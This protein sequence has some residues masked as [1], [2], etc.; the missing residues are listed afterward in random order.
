MSRDGAPNSRRSLSLFESASAQ[1]DESLFPPPSKT[2]KPLA[3]LDIMC[4]FKLRNGGIRVAGRPSSETGITGQ[5]HHATAFAL[6]KKGF[7]RHLLHEELRSDTDMKRRVLGYVGRLSTLERYQATMST[8]LEG[9]ETSSA[10]KKSTEGLVAGTAETVPAKPEALIKNELNN[11]VKEVLGIYSEKRAFKQQLRES[12]NDLQVDRNTYKGMLKDDQADIK[13]L[14]SGDPENKAREIEAL[15][16]LFKRRV[17]RGDR[18]S[19]LR[20]FQESLTQI[21]APLDPQAVLK[22]VQGHGLDRVARRREEIAVAK[23]AN[24]TRIE[25]VC[26][27]LAEL[28]VAYYNRIRGVAFNTRDAYEYPSDRMSEAASLMYLDER[29]GEGVDASAEAEW[30][31]SVVQRS[32]KELRTIEAQMKKL[33]F[34]ISKIG[35]GDEKHAQLVEKLKGKEVKRAATQK[36]LANP[37]GLVKALDGLFDYPAVRIDANKVATKPGER[38]NNPDKLIFLMA[39]HLHIA[40]SVYPEAVAKYN[41]QEN[42]FSYLPNPAFAK[43]IVVPFVAR[44]M[45]AGWDKVTPEDYLNDAVPELLDWMKVFSK[46]NEILEETMTAYESSSHTTS[47]HSSSR[48]DTGSSSDNDP[49]RDEELTEGGPRP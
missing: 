46:K 37:P 49:D 31:P 35:E 34:H 4:L 38:D 20:D 18:E 43:E 13:S 29:Y 39:R 3:M 48:S 12:E 26:E 42:E 15:M 1:A 41:T 47:N 40:F 8:T 36:K 21:S 2:P 19:I 11:A 17:V 44:V 10:A 6:I 23:E 14:L 25:D 7:T 27:T 5:A 30:V 22:T 32:R 24:S 33:T 16:N 45:I 9:A 28:S